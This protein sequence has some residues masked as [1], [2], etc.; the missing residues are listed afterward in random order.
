MICMSLGFMVLY[1]K[2]TKNN[3]DTFGIGALGRTSASDFELGLMNFVFSFCH[4]VVT[5]SV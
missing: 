1:S 3:W 4:F 5:I 2:K